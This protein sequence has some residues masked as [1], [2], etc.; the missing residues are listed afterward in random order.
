MTEDD[1]P[2]SNG[3]DP[4]D[5]LLRLRAEFEQSTTGL[6]RSMTHIRRHLSAPAAV[7][8]AILVVAVWT[9]WNVA[10]GRGAFDPAPY[11]ALN[12]VV[13]VG[14]LIATILILAGQSREDE[15]AKR[16]A[17]LTLHLAAESEQKVAKL[18][19]LVEEQRRDS[20][21]MPNRADEEAEQMSSPAGPRA[22]LE[23]L[24][25]EEAL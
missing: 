17:R 16:I 10:L 2:P 24:E 15:A 22:V 6:Q 3:G 21:V 8:I 7:I 11:P 23:R 1:R 25:N 12:T 14:A 19:Q 13:S 5:E 18:I 4:H 9:I 20:A